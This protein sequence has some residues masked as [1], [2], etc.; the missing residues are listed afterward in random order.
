MR[1]SALEAK[2]VKYCRENGILTYKFSSPSQRG[3]PDRVMMKDR[4]VMFME[5]K[6]PGKT[7]TALQLHEIEKIR[8]SG[9]VA[10]WVDSFINA[11]ALLDFYFDLEPQT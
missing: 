11:K 3:V 6:A 2:I 10:S 5:V 1:E 8:K 7:P 4:R 9:V